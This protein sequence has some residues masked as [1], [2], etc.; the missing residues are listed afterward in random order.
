LD[1]E[2]NGDNRKEYTYLILIDQQKNTAET[3]WVAGFQDA[4]QFT[5]ISLQPFAEKGW[6]ALESGQ[7][8][9]ETNQT[10]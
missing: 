9:P 8:N 6:K 5:S 10:A 2:D 3:G 7:F 1:H 4:N